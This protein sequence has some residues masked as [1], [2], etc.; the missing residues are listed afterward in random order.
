MKKFTT[1][2]EGVFQRYQGGSFL[3]GD[4]VKFR[5]GAL[6]EEW[7]KAQPASLMEKLKQFAEGDLNLRVS[8][9]QALRPA[10]QGS[11]QQ[12]NQQC[13]FYCDVVQETAPNR[14]SEFLTIPAYLLELNNPEDVNL[15]PI[16]DS[17]RYDDNTHIKPD[18][19]K[20]EGSADGDTTKPHSQTRHAD[21][22]GKLEK[23]NTSTADS[24]AGGT[25]TKWADEP[26]GGNYPKMS[27]YMEGLKG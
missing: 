27:I 19:V 11:V 18:E 1:L 17:L 6:S 24:D 5:D 25:G 13:D 22:G 12:D 14:W 2:L 20:E 9:V 7:C 3:T 4:L 8:S 23:S 26:G 21:T 15:A 16:P 10:V